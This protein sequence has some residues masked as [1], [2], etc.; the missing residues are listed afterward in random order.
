MPARQD[1]DGGQ[2]QLA[3]AQ[4]VDVVLHAHPLEHPVDDTVVRVEHPQE[5]DAAGGHGDVARHEDQ[6]AHR[7]VGLGQPVEQVRQHQAQAQVD[8]DVEEGVDQRHLDG[9]EQVLGGGLGGEQPDPVLEADVLVGAAGQPPVSEADV[10]QLGDGIIGGQHQQQHCGQR[11]EEIRPGIPFRAQAD[12]PPVDLDAARL[13]CHVS[14][15]LRNTGDGQAHPPV[16]ID[17]SVTRQP[18]CR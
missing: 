15:S 5:D 11:H 6:R 14:L 18:A 9:V 1:Q 17:D 8:G 16:Q 10:D 12:L 4:P 7:A 3:V 2:R 13:L